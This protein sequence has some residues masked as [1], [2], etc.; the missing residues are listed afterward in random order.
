MVDSEFHDRFLQEIDIA[1]QTAGPPLHGLF[2][3]ADFDAGN[4]LRP[5]I[6]GCQQRSR[7]G[8]RDNESEPA[9]HE[10]PHSSV[11]H[12]AKLRGASAGCERYHSETSFAH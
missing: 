11:A 2:D 12:H 1:L 3:G 4:I 5:R 6:S 10:N 8:S 9:D 7:Q